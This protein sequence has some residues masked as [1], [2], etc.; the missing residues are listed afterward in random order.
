MYILSKYKII[1]KKYGIRKFIWVILDV[2]MLVVDFCSCRIN[3]LF[4]LFNCILNWI[5]ILY[6]ILFGIYIV[7]IWL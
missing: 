5:N 3:F 7:Y 2:I 6:I 4:L 1:K